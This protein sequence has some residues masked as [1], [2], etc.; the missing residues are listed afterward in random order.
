MKL[1]TLTMGLFRVN[2]YL[3]FDETSKEI[4]LI[5][6]GGD[7]EQ[8]KNAIDKLGGNLKYLLN[9]HAHM[10]HIAGDYDIQ[11]YYHVPVYIH[12]N[13]EN[14]VKELKKYL[15][16][17]GMPDYEIPQ[18]VTY[19]EDGAIFKIGNKEIKT[20]HTPGHTQGGVGYLI[21]DML[22]SGDTLFEESI[23]RTDLEGGNFNQL[24]NSVKTKL[25]LLNDDIK[26]YPGHGDST[27]I[28]HEKKYNS[29]V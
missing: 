1:V 18:D 6:A 19:I 3:L 27:T 16:F 11:N 22:F 14:L 5:D 12:K 2:N 29:Y 23:G 26:V 21:D 4:V 28:G 10:D 8:T 15:Q 24:V 9:T 25:L 17:V 20:I 13:D 7:F